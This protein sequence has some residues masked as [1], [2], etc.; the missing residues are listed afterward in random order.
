MSALAVRRAGAGF[1]LRALALA[2]RLGSLISGSPKA[3]S[4]SAPHSAAIFTSPAS[5]RAAA[6]LPSRRSRWSPPASGEPF[7]LILG[8]DRLFLELH[9][10]AERVTQGVGQLLEL[11]HTLGVVFVESA[12]VPGD[13]G[14]L[15]KKHQRYSELR[16]DITRDISHV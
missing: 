6:S 16:G 12:R 13:L 5:R 4:T 1:D 11:D 10:P 3:K 2:V 9:G 14:C 7:L 8:I 15:L